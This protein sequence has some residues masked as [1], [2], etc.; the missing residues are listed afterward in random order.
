MDLSEFFYTERKLIKDLQI[1]LKDFEPL[2]KDPRFLWTSRPFKNF[3]LLPR[4]AWGNWLVCVVLREMHGRDITFMEDNDGDGFIVDRD[5]RIVFPTEHVNALEIPQGRKWPSGEQRIIDAIE[6]KIKRG[7][8]YASGKVLVVFFDGAGYFLRSRV[9]ENIFG[10]HNFEAVF[11]V[12]LGESTE[13]GYSY[14]VT[15]FRDSFVGQ[16]I[17]H[18]VDI[19]RVF[20]NWEVTKILQ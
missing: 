12:G 2:V 16:S 18:R 13:S 8:E 1:V 17:T 5:R 9:R 4:E 10:R 14:Y 20:E 11:C 3:N 19:D 6:L 7:P 15:E